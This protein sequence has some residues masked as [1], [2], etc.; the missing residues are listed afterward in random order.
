[1]PTTRVAREI[2]SAIRNIA[3]ISAD[4]VR[5]HYGRDRRDL[6]KQMIDNGFDDRRGKGRFSSWS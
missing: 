4:L 6:E 3:E 2:G 5:S 1:M